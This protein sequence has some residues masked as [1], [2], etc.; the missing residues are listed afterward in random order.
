M[1]SWSLLC[2]ELPLILPHPAPRRAGG[3]GAKAILRVCVVTENSR[4]HR[5]LSDNVRPEAV[6]ILRNLR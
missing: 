3:R 6:P 2:R 4:E 5:Q 1:E